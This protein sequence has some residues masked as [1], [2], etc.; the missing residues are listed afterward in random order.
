MHRKPGTDM[1]EPI[2]ISIEP[3]GMGA[4]HNLMC[5]LCGLRK[6]V[7]NMSPVWAFQPCDEC[8]SKFLGGQLKRERKWK[9][10]LTWV[11]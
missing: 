11:T 6:A 4:T 8:S 5:W 7:Y 3:H 10:W 1:S 9:V 2:H